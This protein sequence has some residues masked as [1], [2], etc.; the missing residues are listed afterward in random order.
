MISELSERA[1]SLHGLSLLL[2]QFC[3]RLVMREPAGG[4]HR[5]SVG[6]A[7][8]L[9]SLIILGFSNF[10]LVVLE[11]ALILIKDINVNLGRQNILLVNID[12]RLRGI[13]LA[14]P[15]LILGLSMLL[16]CLRDLL[17][18]LGDL[19]EADHKGSTTKAATND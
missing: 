14:I 4:I 15:L 9:S 19:V 3:T 8:I 13:L 12:L 10:F 5:K 6:V 11:V 7:E 2:D 18:G 16:L 17:G 1:S